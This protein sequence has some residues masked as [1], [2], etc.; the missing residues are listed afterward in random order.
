MPS[1]TP[2]ALREANKRFA[3][4]AMGTDEAGPAP[5]WTKKSYSNYS[6]EERVH[7]GK[8]AAEHEPT[9]A[10]RHVIVPESTAHLLKKQ[11]F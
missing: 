2:E 6:P 5:K 8:Y 7:I 10:S 4:L 1:L 11:Y 3:S 9:K